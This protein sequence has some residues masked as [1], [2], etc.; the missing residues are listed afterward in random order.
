MGLVSEKMT[1]IAQTTTIRLVK[2]FQQLGGTPFIIRRRP[3]R[4]PFVL[5]RLCC[6][7]LWVGVGYLNYMCDLANCRESCTAVFAIVYA[8]IMV[9]DIEVCSTHSV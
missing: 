7:E 5:Q 9:A 1:L 2:R 6:R 4:Y 3:H 8:R